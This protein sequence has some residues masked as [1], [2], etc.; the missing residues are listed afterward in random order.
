MDKSLTIMKRFNLT[1]KQYC[2]LREYAVADTTL[3]GL[4]DVFNVSTITMSQHMRNLR[5]RF[6]VKTNVGLVVKA[7]RLGIINLDKNKDEKNDREQP[8]KQAAVSSG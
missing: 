5:H 4:S 1:H 2:I 7:H 3:Q 6:N 8:G